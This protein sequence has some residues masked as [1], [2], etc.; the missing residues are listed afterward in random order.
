MSGRKRESRFEFNGKLIE[1]YLRLVNVERQVTTASGEIYT[2]YGILS[3]DC[4]EVSGGETQFWSRNGI[5]FK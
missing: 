1:S 5:Q 2:K 3:R 4:D